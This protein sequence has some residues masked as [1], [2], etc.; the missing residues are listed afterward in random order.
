MQK[1]AHIDDCIVPF[2]RDVRWDFFPFP[3]RPLLKGEQTE[4]GDEVNTTKRDHPYMGWVRIGAELANY[5][6]LILNKQLIF[7]TTRPWPNA[8]GATEQAGI[9]AQ[10]LV[11][12]DAQIVKARELKTSAEKMLIELE[13]MSQ[14]L[15]KMIGRIENK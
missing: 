15:K 11:S 5:P 4:N 12:I 13:T 6:G 1:P 14:N 10:T 3:Y 9:A 8:N 2:C 7:R